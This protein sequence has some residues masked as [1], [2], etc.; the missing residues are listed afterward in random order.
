[1]GTKKFLEVKVRPEHRADYCA[2]QVVPIVKVRTDAQHFPIPLS[3]R[4]SLR[5]I[6]LL[7]CNFI[8]TEMSILSQSSSAGLLKTLFLCNLSFR[9][10]VHNSFQLNCILDHLNPRNNLLIVVFFQLEDA[11]TSEIF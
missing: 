1:V 7:L 11:W 5:E 4:E 10:R 3:L 9:D 2:V 6:Y 8:E